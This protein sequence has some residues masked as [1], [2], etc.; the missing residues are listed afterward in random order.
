MPSLRDI[1]NDPS[2]VMQLAGCC[3]FA[4]A[5]MA[6]LEQRLNSVD[7]L[8]RCAFSGRRFRDF[9]NSEDIYAQIQLLR[10]KG[11]IKGLVADM[12]DVRYP[13]PQRYYSTDQVMCMAL[14]L[15]FERQFRDQGHDYWTRS[16]EFSERYS[17]RTGIWGPHEKFGILFPVYYAETQDIP[18]GMFSKGFIRSNFPVENLS[19][20]KSD[21]AVTPAALME[22]LRMLEINAVAHFPINQNTWGEARRRISHMQ[23]LNV[24]LQG[25]FL[26][27]VPYRVKWC[28]RKKSYLSNQQDCPRWFRSLI[29]GT[30]PAGGNLDPNN[31]HGITHWIYVPNCPNRRPAAPD[32]FL[33][34]TWGRERYFA[35]R[36]MSNGPHIPAAQRRG[37]EHYPKY[38][39]LLG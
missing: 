23:R 4:S 24:A 12:E 7:A 2:L 10:R 21:F 30:G 34:W 1:K 27:F 8:F 20:Q 15:L 25:D 37:I 18:D 3:G 26:P 32:E 33:C 29:I 13:D 38:A 11:I 19:Y 9:V 6:A 35:E 36:I 16:V 17:W 22:L 28:F 39:I 31:F 5:L 14:M